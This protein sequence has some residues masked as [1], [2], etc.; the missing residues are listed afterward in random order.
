ML[1]D[2]RSSTTFFFEDGRRWGGVGK[3]SASGE[4]GGARF[5]RLPPLPEMRRQALVMAV[6]QVVLRSGW[7]PVHGAICGH[8]RGKKK[9]LSL[10]LGRRFR[11][12]PEGGGAMTSSWP[13]L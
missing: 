3:T 10:F 2:S 12:I 4:G 7:W 11:A 13:R 1:A 6:V 9:I 5:T 8:V